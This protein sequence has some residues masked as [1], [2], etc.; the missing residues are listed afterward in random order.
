MTGIILAILLLGGLALFTGLLLQISAAHFS[1]DDSDVINAINELLPQSQC[2]QCGF[3]GCRPYAEAV[4]EGESINRCPP[5]GTALIE[6]LAGLLNRPELP[7]AEELTAIDQPVS[8]VIRENDCIGCSLCIK[9]CPVDAII[10][11]PQLMHTI[12][13]SD[14]TGCGL[15]LPPCPVDCIDLIPVSHSN[16][17]R[18]LPNFDIPCIHCSE[19]MLACPRELAPQQLF[20]AANNAAHADQLRLSDCIECSLC[21]RSCPSE[22]PLTRTFQ[23]MKHNNK[24]LLEERAMALRFEK[25]YARH[26]QRLAGS[27]SQ[28]ATRPK[29]SEAE[30]LLTTLR[31][32]LSP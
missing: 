18:R 1:A 21:D 4:A 6:N 7:L 3:A 20:L 22:L 8:A 26:E 32:Q 11:A 16:A 14:C 5:G 12:V 9:A 31:N 28:V 30:E 15:C 23:V 10:G 17:A 29:P 19:C 13:Q 24:I 2:A 27:A 25:K